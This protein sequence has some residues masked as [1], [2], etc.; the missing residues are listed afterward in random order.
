MRGKG[1]IKHGD[2]VDS[3]TPFQTRPNCLSN[4]TRMLASKELSA[5]GCLRK[6]IVASFG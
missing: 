4:L 3:R 2:Y 1:T 6:F 5:K